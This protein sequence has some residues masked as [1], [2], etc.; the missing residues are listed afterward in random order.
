MSQGR[1]RG[2]IEV[3]QIRP[4]RLLLI[5]PCLA[6]CLALFEGNVCLLNVVDNH[7]STYFTLENWLENLM[8]SNRQTKP[9]GDSL[10]S[11]FASRACLSAS[12]L[13]SELAALTSNCPQATIITFR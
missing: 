3:L 12:L 7:F 9:K 4:A 5:S 6:P 1:L 8:K 13:N 11:L 2:R 10:A